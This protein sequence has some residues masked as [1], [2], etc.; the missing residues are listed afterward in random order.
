MPVPAGAIAERRLIDRLLRARAFTP[1]T[2]QPLTGLRWVEGR[3]L[4]RLIAKHVIL[5]PQP[6]RYYLDGPALADRYASQRGA[7]AVALIFVILVL[8]GMVFLGG[9]STSRIA[10]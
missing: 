7:R 9:V 8:M 2:S 4:Q 1:D 6:G 5:E 3:R 10:F